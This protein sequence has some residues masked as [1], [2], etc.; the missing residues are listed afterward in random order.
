MIMRVC[1]SSLS[2]STFEPPESTTSARPADSTQCRIASSWVTSI[3]LYG[4]GASLSFSGFSF[5][6]LS[7][8]TSAPISIATRAA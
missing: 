1:A 2:S 6:M 5:G 3:S 4:A 8:T 7:F